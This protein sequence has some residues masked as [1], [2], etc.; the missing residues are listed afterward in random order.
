SGRGPRP[1][2]AAPASTPRALE[3]RRR[4]ALAAVLLPRPLGDVPLQVRQG[5]RADGEAFPARPLEVVEVGAGGGEAV[6]LH[7][8][9]AVRPEVSLAELWEGEGAGAGLAS[10]ST[11]PPALMKATTSAPSGTRGTFCST[12][13]RVFATPPRR[14]SAVVRSP[15]SS[16]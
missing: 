10:S 8:P 14:A 6:R 11:R 9:V 5:Q 13:M 4:E 2:S 16:E 3:R 15:V 1:W 12:S 7:R